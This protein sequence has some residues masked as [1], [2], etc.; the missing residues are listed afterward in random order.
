MSD[1]CLCQNELGRYILKE[2]SP[3]LAYLQEGGPGWW[4]GTTWQGVG[5][6]GIR[7]GSVRLCKCLSVQGAPCRQGGLGAYMGAHI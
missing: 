7:L 3:H 1:K 2:G 6:L 4:G 5:P